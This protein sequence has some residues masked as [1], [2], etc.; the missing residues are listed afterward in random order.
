M[1]EGTA[2]QLAYE[3]ILMPLALTKRGPSISQAHQQDFINGV[4]H[5]SE[6]TQIKIR[7]LS[8]ND[9]TEAVQII[10]PANW[11]QTKQDWQRLIRLEPQGCFAAWVEGRL[12]AT[13]TTT[14]YGTELA[15]IGMMIVAQEYRRRGLATKLMHMAMEYLRAKGVTTVKLDATPLGQPV[16]EAL[17]FVS[18]GLIERWEAVARPVNTANGLSFLEMELGAELRAFDREAFQANRARVL[19]TLLRDCCVAP[20][21]FTTPNGRL[22]GYAL[23][24][25]GAAAHYIGPVV[26]TNDQTALLLLDGIM[27]QLAGKKVYLD[28]YTGFGAES[29]ALLQHGFVR[30]RALVR[31]RYGKNNSAGASAMVLAIAG[32]ELG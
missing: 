5:M 20:L 6:E 14:I 13:I 3:N 1:A 30:Q 2:L 27:N 24:R 9:L 31:M 19:T 26:A 15:W 4:A 17:G 28:F 11:N 10:K 29:D 21:A 23:A 8:E 12:V 22:Q 25:Q 16:Y 32:P 7:L 18:E